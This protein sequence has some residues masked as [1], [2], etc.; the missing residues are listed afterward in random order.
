MNFNEVVINEYR[1][2]RSTQHVPSPLEFYAGISD[3]IKDDFECNEKAKVFRDVSF[4]LFPVG[5]IMSDGAKRGREA[6]LNRYSEVQNIVDKNTFFDFVETLSFAE[7]SSSSKLPSNGGFSKNESNT[8][9]VSNKQQVTTNKDSAVTSDNSASHATQSN[10]QTQAISKQ[11]VNSLRSQFG[12][13]KFVAIVTCLLIAITGITLMVIYFS[14]TTWQW[15]IGIVGGLLV[16][17][18]LWG[19]SYAFDDIDTYIPFAF[20]HPIIIVINIVLAINNMENYVIIFGCISVMSII[21]SLV[22]TIM[23]F[24]EYETGFGVLHVIEGSASLI[25]MIVLLIIIL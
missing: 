15:I 6:L 12:W 18:I 8:N 13:G 21:S 22:S 9:H 3:V 25:A 17:G 7:S 10:V 14:W 19:I 4:V 24:G 16:F 2:W 5:T 23:A 1:R 20:I 11:P